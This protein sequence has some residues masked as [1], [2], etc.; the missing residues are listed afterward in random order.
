MECV[1]LRRWSARLQAFSWTRASV[2]RSWG[3]VE[4]ISLNLF[5][6]VIWSTDLA[7]H[8]A[9]SKSHAFWFDWGS[10]GKR[11]E[12]DGIQPSCAT[13]KSFP[14]RV[15]D[16][17]HTKCGWG[18]IVSS[19]FRASHLKCVKAILLEVIAFW[20]WRTSFGL[21]S[22]FERKMEKKNFTGEGQGLWERIVI[23]DGC[24]FQLLFF[25]PWTTTLVAHEQFQLRS[26]LLQTKIVDHRIRILS[27]GSLGTSRNWVTGHPISAPVESRC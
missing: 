15:G 2:I 5:N 26:S 3:H 8:E 19:V 25:F 4:R 24:Y 1:R 22:F 21:L 9:A 7:S 6:R 27:I 16:A 17:W 18:H 23:V 14:R 10:A 12:V 11:A 20:L 13:R